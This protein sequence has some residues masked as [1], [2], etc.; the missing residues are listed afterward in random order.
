[1]N[2]DAASPASAVNSAVAAERP[3]LRACVEQVLDDFFHDLNGQ[4]PSDLHA[5]VMRE[6]EEPLLRRVLQ[7]AQGNMTV[8]AGM[9]GINRATLRKR[10]SHYDARG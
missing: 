3:S 10:L 7:E 2:K 1:M 4:R 6:V 8:A 5:L 9:L